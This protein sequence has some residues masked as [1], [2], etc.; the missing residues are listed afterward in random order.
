[1]SLIERSWALGEAKVQP[2]CG[3]TNLWR[4]SAWF[5]DKKPFSVEQKIEFHKTKEHPTVDKH[6]D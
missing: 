4:I 6:D 1:M 5:V 3:V 2:T